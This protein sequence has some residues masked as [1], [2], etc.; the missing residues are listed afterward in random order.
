VRELFPFFMQSNNEDT[1]TDTSGFIAIEHDLGP[2]E[3][4]Q[5]GTRPADATRR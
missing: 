5:S 3:N 2:F 1:A 4:R